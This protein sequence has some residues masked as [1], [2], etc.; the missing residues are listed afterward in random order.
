MTHVRVDTSQRLAAVRQRA[1]DNIERLYLT[2]LLTEHRGRIK[3]SAQAAGITTRQLHKLMTKHGLKK[4]SF[5]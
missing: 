5:K 3:T 4:E 2:E 1:A